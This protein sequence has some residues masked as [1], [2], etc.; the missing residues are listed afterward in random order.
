MGHILD[1]L[2]TLRLHQ[3]REILAMQSMRYP[4][5][6]SNFYVCD[7]VYTHQYGTPG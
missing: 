5:V 3:H 7:N 1:H 4:T 2:Q 6:V